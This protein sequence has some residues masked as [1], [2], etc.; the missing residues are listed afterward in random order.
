MKKVYTLVELWCGAIKV[1][2]VYT[3]LND[4]TISDMKEMVRSTESSDSDD[5]LEKHFLDISLDEEEI[6]LWD[7]GTTE[8]WILPSTLDEGESG[9]E[10]PQLGTVRFIRVTWDN[11]WANEELP[12]VAEIP[13]YVSDDDVA[14]YISDYYGVDVRDWEDISA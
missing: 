13:G 3:K 5:E 9:E 14:S 7:D 10:D 2:K 8:Y 11:E 6:C 4:R 1:R 12:E